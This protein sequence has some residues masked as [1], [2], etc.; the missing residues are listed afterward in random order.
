M[1]VF[2]QLS[3]ISKSFGGVQALQNIDLT[4]DEGEVH[5]IVGENGS[6]KSTLIKIIAGVIAPSSGGRITVGGH[7]YGRLNPAKSTASGIQVIYQDLS[8]FPNLSVAEN[9]GV[10]QHL[11]A[12]HM[13]NWPAVRAT[14][15]TAMERLGVSLDLDAPVSQL[16]IS[17]RQLVAICRAVAGEAR[18]LIMDEPTA[19]LTQ[20]EVGDLLKL[21]GEL[22]QK[23]IC[24]IFV[25]H[26]LNEVLQV[27]DRVTILRDGRSL[28]TF[29]ARE[30][31]DRKLGFLMTGKEFEYNLVKRDMGDRSPYLSVA[32][33]CRANEYD[34]IS[35]DLRPGEVLGV[36]GLLG[37]GR[38]E[39][40]HSLF[41]MTRPDSGE[42]RVDGRVVDMR[43]NRDAIAL[44]IAYV[45]ED[46]LRLGLVLDQPISSNVLI[47]IFN[48]VLNRIGLFDRGKKS[49]AVDN[50]IRRLAIKIGGPEDAAK[51]LSG[52]NQ[53]R[54][55]IAKWLARNPRILI[56]DSPTAGVD[57]AAKDGI[58]EIV[59]GLAREG[60][61][62]IMISN[63]V[64]EVF[65]HCDR[66]MIMRGG[67]L[68]GECIPYSSSERELEEAVDA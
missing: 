13:V 66:V 11:G 54:L 21:V 58:Y 47:T 18:L 40:A 65:Y 2:L 53:Q 24:I 64:P 67:R 34:D 49:A 68:A 46:R 42:I 50:W 38:T 28:G 39:L 4:L 57:I 7:E 63:E 31:N 45:S 1:S 30:M 29:P 16:S 8:L 22:R 27:A 12:P 10:A 43:S 6:G 61:A 3:N 23:G 37:S 33:L 14:A 44:G 48:Q 17:G 56:L 59:K 9:I 32:N 15:R 52:G 35:F 20:Q 41:G 60:V 25:S 5:C 36:I 55:V 62:I 19:S 51:T 26:R